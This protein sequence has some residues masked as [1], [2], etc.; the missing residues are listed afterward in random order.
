MDV[1]FLQEPETTVSKGLVHDALESIK[2]DGLWLYKSLHS[3]GI[4]I[5]NSQDEVQEKQKFLEKGKLVELKKFKGKQTVRFALADGGR[6][7]LRLARWDI[8]NDDGSITPLGSLTDDLPDSTKWESSWGLGSN[9]KTEAELTFER[10]TAT[11]TFWSK[12]PPTGRPKEKTKHQRVFN[13]EWHAGATSRRQ[14]NPMRLAGLAKI[15]LGIAGVI[16]YIISAALGGDFDGIDDGDGDKSLRDGKDAVKKGN[17]GGEDDNGGNGGV[18]EGGGQ[19]D[20][21]EEE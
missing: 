12:D 6:P 15:G 8:D 18:E 17:D 5:Y 2:R 3:Y 16:S 20:N 13:E 1:I 9:A 19:F 7:D 4:V 14:S 10:R 11:V 21:F